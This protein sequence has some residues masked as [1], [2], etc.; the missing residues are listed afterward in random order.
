MKKDI[1]N[2]D[3][4]QVLVDAFYNKVAKDDTIGYIF[5][6]VQQVDWASHLP[7]M[8]SFW[9]TVLFGVRSYKGNPMLKHILVNRNES[10]TSS[11]FMQWLKLWGE[12]IDEHF[13]GRKADMAKQ[14]ADN[15]AIGIQKTLGI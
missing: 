13:M 3:D 9:Q 8:Y 4:I 6:D 1:E 15:M 11:H 7:Q 14:R 2:L 10:L 12:T 5:E